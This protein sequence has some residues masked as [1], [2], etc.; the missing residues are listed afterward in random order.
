M[1]NKKK[2]L[3]VSFQSLTEESGAGMARLGYYLSDVLYKR[4]LLKDF[5]VF[6]KGKH[7]TSFPSSPVSRWSRYMLFALNKMQ[8]KLHFTSQHNFRFIQE[9]LFDFFCAHK[10]NSSI[11]T[12]LVTQPFLPRTFKKAKSL[13]VKIIF[14]PAN[15]EENYI[16]KLLAE[17]KQKRHV[18]GVDAYT[19][20]DRINFFNKAIKYVD[21]VLCIHPTVYTSY[22]NATSVKAEIV[23]M[24]GH[25]KPDLHAAIIENNPS[26]KIFRVGYIAH[27]VLLKGLQY[28]LEAWNDIMNTNKEAGNMQ[29]CIAGG[30]DATMQ[31]IINRDFSSVKNVEYAGHINSV[32]GFLTDKHLFVVPS[33]VD[34][35]PYTALEAAYHSIPIIITENCGSAELLSRGESGCKVIPIKDANAIKE[36]ILW[37]FNNRE[38]ARKMGAS[39]KHNLETYDMNELIVNI[40]DYLQKK[41][42]A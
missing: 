39:A 14:I 37:A 29:L 35:G 15:P 20:D 5:V 12:L 18:D 26:E 27:T 17:E 13:G 36:N 7:T 9:K 3:V 38:A 42:E 23:K 28:L 19:F 41:Q 1:E 24:I 11:S 33:L 30:I 6:S 34:A 10:I 4:G 31:G 25:V 22:Q 21:T 2:I 16:Y 8:N 40:A 32:D